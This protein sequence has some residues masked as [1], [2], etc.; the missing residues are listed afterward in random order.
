VGYDIS[1]HPVD[2]DLIRSRLIPF[3]MG[4]G[5]IDDL[6]DRAVKVGRVAREAG[7][8][9]KALVQ[10]EFR[11]TEQ[12]RQ[13]APPR[14][15]EYQVPGREPTRMERW[16]NK[17]VPT[18]TRTREV[19]GNTIGIPGFD[20]DLHYWG[21]PFLI[22]ADRTDDVLSMYSQYLETNPEDAETLQGLI[23]QS[24]K[25]LESKRRQI[26]ADMESEVIK[27]LEEYYPLLDHLE[28]EEDREYL[29][30]EKLRERAGQ[31]LR[32]LRKAYQKRDQEI[33][34]E[35][36]DGRKLTPREILGYAPHELIEFAARILPGWVGRGF[37]FP[38]ALFKKIKVDVS[39]VFEK[40]TSL[41]EPLL[42]D[43][44]QIADHLHTTIPENF[45]LGGYVPPAKVERFVDLVNK[46]RWEL[47]LAE[48]EK[49][50]EE[51]QQT[52]EGSTH[53]HE[54]SADW[55][56]II[57]PATYAQQHGLGFIEAAEVYAGPFGWMN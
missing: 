34:I 55:H 47:V 18:I 13:V 28:L 54:L 44:P 49:D 32:L 48:D 8:W 10:L 3:I 12:Q 19:P 46:H 5:E 42:Q 38:T 24:I 7:R 16:L 52:Q 40:P 57:E 27:T 56:K 53:Q 51:E 9:A 43:V 41:F 20:A 33:Q 11:A 4:E 23:E 14:V 25:H 2:V 15:I 1:H 35:L 6:I 26:R 37:V 21:R 45:A 36:P 31:E 22:S 39:K 29:T 30:R 17:P 50:S